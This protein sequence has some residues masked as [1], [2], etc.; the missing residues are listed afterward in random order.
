MLQGVFGPQCG[1]EGVLDQ[2]DVGV[3]RRVLDAGELLGHRE[4][5]GRHLAGIHQ[6]HGA[7]KHANVRTQRKRDFPTGVCD[8]R[9]RLEF[10]QRK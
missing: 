4:E 6:Q 3:F 9:E 10:D 8:E 7:A 5:F 2:G 1:L